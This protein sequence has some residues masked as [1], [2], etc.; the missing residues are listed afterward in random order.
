MATYSA[1]WIPLFFIFILRKKGEFLYDYKQ[2][3]ILII[4]MALIIIDIMLISGRP[5]LY[6]QHLDTYKGKG[7]EREGEEL[8]Y[9]TGK[10]WTI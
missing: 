9:K 7:K 8:R 6:Y 4:L 2:K 3:S 5:C 1:R 10:T